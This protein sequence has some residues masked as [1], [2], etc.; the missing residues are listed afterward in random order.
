MGGGEKHT[1][2][3]NLHVSHQPIISIKAITPPNG[4]RRRRSQRRFLAGLR[5]D[6]PTTQVHTPDLP[7]IIIEPPASLPQSPCS[8][9]SSFNLGGGSRSQFLQ[10]P[11]FDLVECLSLHL[12]QKQSR[13]E[14]EKHQN[15]RHLSI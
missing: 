13:S 11:T 14:Q 1:S 4:E 6:S 7:L 9:S 10:R 12:D 3:T 8:E 5:K 2:S 15:Q